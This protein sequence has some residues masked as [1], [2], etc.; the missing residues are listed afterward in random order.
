MYLWNGK[1][2]CETDLVWT[3][4]TGKKNLMW[5]RRSGRVKRNFT[6]GY[7]HTFGLC[8]PFP[9]IKK[10]VLVLPPVYSILPCFAAPQPKLF[11]RDGYINIFG[12]T[13]IF[14]VTMTSSGEWFLAS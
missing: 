12:K 10:A 3:K 6:N 11:F 9:N 1:C 7:F 13:Q 2:Y 14:T 4:V 8:N 5:E